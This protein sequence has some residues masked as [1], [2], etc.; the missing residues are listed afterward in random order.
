MKWIY[1]YIP[2]NKGKN[3][4]RFV[5]TTGRKRGNSFIEPGKIFFY[6]GAL[7]LVTTGGI[8]PYFAV[9]KITLFRGQIKAYFSFT[10]YLLPVF[11]GMGLDHFTDP[12]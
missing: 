6:R 8:I 10:D 11:S 1:F 5:G 2:D 7:R 9:N 4:E 12:A 3:Q